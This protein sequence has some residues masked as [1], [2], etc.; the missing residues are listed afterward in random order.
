MCSRDEWSWRRSR[1]ILEVKHDKRRIEARY[2]K[3][4]DG[5][6]E[7]FKAEI[8]RQ[9]SV[10]NSNS[11]GATRGFWDKV[12]NYATDKASG[13]QSHHAIN[14]LKSLTSVG[15]A[16]PELVKV[17]SLLLLGFDSCLHE[18]FEGQAY[19][20]QHAQKADAGCLAC[21]N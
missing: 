8:I 2:T 7:V 15:L 21:K 11:N 12:A 5:Y 17:L 20:L 13:L 3:E 1:A 10:I 19:R 18:V 14:I 6:D 4:F 16:K 9:M